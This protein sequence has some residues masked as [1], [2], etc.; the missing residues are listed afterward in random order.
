MFARN[1]LDKYFVAGIFR[2]PLD[3]GTP[4]SVPQSTICYS[5]IPALDSSRTVGVKINWSLGR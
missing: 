5:N 3:G 2:T 4:T 1:L